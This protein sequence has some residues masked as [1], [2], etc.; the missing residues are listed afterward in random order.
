MSED[1]LKFNDLPEKQNGGNEDPFSFLDDLPK[2]QKDY[3]PFSF[4]D[5][6]DE[7]EKQPPVE[8]LTLEDWNLTE[9]DFIKDRSGKLARL[10]PEFK[11]EKSGIDDQITVTNKRTGKSDYFDLGS[12]DLFRSDFEQ[13]NDWI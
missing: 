4:L 10:Y 1:V 8:Q 11:F 3:D 5:D 7:G 9:D 12:T 6:L 2:N 13:F